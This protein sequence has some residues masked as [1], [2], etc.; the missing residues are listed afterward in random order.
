M[1]VKDIKATVSRIKAVSVSV[2]GFIGRH[3]RASIAV[4]VALLLAGPLVTGD[5][6]LVFLNAVGLGFG[7][8][9]LRR[10]VRP[11]G[12]PRTGRTRQGQRQ[13]AARAQQA[14]RTARATQHEGGHDDDASNDDWW[15]W[16]KATAQSGRAGRPADRG[17]V[18]G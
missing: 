17:D 10:F 16:D 7:A 2:G 4:G 18:Q 1:H 11:N 12:R 15:D 14:Q 5:G 8:L 9:L 3:K 6:E 13:Q